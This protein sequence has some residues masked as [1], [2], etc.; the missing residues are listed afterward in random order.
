M[1]QNYFLES[2]KQVDVTSHTTLSKG[3]DPNTLYVLTLVVLHG[4]QHRTTACW[5]T[6]A[7][8]S[9]MQLF[10]FLFK[11]NLFINLPLIYNY[12]Y[13]NDLGQLHIL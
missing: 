1:A 3:C 8:Y 10:S 6:L 2:L 7:V 13:F 5:P 9:S 4:V 12:K 11:N